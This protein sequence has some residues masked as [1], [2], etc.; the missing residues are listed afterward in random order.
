[1]HDQRGEDERVT[2]RVGD[3]GGQEVGGHPAA[4]KHRAETA[5]QADVGVA[6]EEGVAGEAALRAGV[7]LQERGQRK[8]RLQATAQV[9][10][11]REAEPRSGHAAAVD[12]VGSV[13]ITG[14]LHGADEDVTGAGERD[15]ALGGCARGA[16]DGGR[17]GQHVFFHEFSC[18]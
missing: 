3:H 14:H 17:K 8:L 7:G 6:R 12:H 13:G 11:A 18:R 1:M 15:R 10:R 4:Q 9:F 5:R 2:Q 16:K